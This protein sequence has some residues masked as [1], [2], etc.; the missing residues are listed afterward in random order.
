MNRVY[1][2]KREITEEMRE[3]MYPE[4]I[5]QIKEDNKRVEWENEETFCE[6]T[7]E[8]SFTKIGDIFN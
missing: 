1:K 7:K 3:S 2:K 5:E 6:R 8:N 4:E